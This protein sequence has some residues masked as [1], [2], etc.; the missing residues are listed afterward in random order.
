MTNIL[1]DLKDHLP[2]F[3]RT[4]DSFSDVV[5]KLEASFVRRNQK[6]DS[7]GE[8]SKTCKPE[9]SGN[10]QNNRNASAKSGNR[11]NKTNAVTASVPQQKT[12]NVKPKSAET[13]KKDGKGR[14]MSAPGPQN[15]SNNN[16]RPMSGNTNPV[17]PSTASNATT[18]KG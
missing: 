2:A 7:K 5:P 6:V 10:N 12:N 14:P 1:K 9:T 11:S 3:K 16:K 17:K 13:S 15:C 8:S 18:N 4:K